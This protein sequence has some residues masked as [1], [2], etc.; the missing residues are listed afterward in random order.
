MS[1][2]NAGLCHDGL[3]SALQS[4]ALEQGVKQVLTEGFTVNHPP[5][6]TVDHPPL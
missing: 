4:A 3:F 1:V 5:G 2:S 6:F